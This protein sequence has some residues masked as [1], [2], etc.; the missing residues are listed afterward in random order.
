VTDTVSVVKDGNGA[1]VDWGLQYSLVKKISK[2]CLIPTFAD[3]GDSVLEQ[4]SH[5]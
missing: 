1:S 5:P 2:K 3:L 4:H